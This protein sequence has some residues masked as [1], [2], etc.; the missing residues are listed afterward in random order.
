MIGKYNDALESFNK[1]YE[2]DPPIWVWYY[3]SF[4]LAKQERFDSACPSEV[5]PQIP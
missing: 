3:Q 4:I 1:T 5:L 2:I